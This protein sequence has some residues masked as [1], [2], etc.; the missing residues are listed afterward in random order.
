MSNNNNNAKLDAMILAG[1]ALEAFEIYYADGVV[2]IEGDGSRREGKELNRRY[3]EAFFGSIEEFHGAELLSTA[4]QGDTSF[5]E[6]I[7]DFTPKNGQ[8]TSMKQIAHRTW[9]DG[10]VVEER[11]YAAN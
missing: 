3:E 2:M 6:W 9:Q 10:C 5:S 8:R 11:F 1:T 4:T 7:F